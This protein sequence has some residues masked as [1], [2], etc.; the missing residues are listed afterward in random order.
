[1][2]SLNSPPLVL[3]LRTPR[4]EVAIARAGVL[5]AALVPVTFLPPL[6]ALIVAVLGS[7]SLYI[8]FRRGKWLGS[9]APIVRI[10]WLPDGPWIVSDSLG[11]TAACELGH[12]S[13]IFANGVWLSLCRVDRK[14]D[15]FH[16]LLTRYSLT[17]P[18]E[19]RRL[20]VRLRMD[21]T[22]PSVEPAAELS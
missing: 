9:S 8:G 16:I 18:Q 6:S 11:R 12:S 5:L 14:A 21:P 10:S 13:R 7:V 19:L 15:R 1:M 2:S 3:E 22:D 17:H 4:P 20:I